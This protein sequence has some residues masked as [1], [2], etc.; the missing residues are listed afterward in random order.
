MIG[1]INT[2]L[3]FIIL[4]SCVELLTL[5]ATLS[6]SFAFMFSNVFSYFANTKMTFKATISF[7][8]YVS[9]FSASIF[10]LFLTLAISYISTLYDLH[11]LIGFCF[12]V[13]LVP[14]LS[15]IIMKFWVFSEKQL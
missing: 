3:H 1:V 9:F 11:Y 13:V 14:A 10:S 8:R 2:I 15:F 12:I 4:V 6:N 5:D 7:S